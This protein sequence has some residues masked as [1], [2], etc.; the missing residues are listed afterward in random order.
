MKLFL[1]KSILLLFL[2]SIGMYMNSCT[3]VRSGEQKKELKSGLSEQTYKPWAYWWWMGSS[4][5]KDGI[6]KNLEA[7]QKAGMGGMHIIPIYGE[8][9]D[10]E[11][12]IEY[13]S[14]KWMEMLA[15]T[16][17]EADRLGMGIDMTTGTGW[18]FGGPSLTFKNS[19]KRL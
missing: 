10:E 7:Y 5:T 19:A 9:G 4:V 16:V 8:K 1:V 6:T 15:H 13:L 2:L 3:K 17:S 11:N 18:P 12:F 14:P